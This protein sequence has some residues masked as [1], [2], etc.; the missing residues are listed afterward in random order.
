MRRKYIILSIDTLRA[1]AG[2]ACSR[3]RRIADVISDSWP[4]SV[5]RREFSLPLTGLYVSRLWTLDENRM[6]PGKH[7]R[8]NL[9]K[10][11]SFWTVGDFATSRFFEYLDEAALEERGTFKVWH[12]SHSF[13][14][15][16]TEY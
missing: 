13:P 15:P 8:I 7:Y 2:R 9:Q 11:K 5:Q 16:L 12:I 3:H 6:E 14:G 4:F 10:E 1:H